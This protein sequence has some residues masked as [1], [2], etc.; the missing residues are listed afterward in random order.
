MSGSGALEELYAPASYEDAS[1][2]HKV[3]AQL[4]LADIQ[5]IQAGRKGKWRESTQLTD[6]EYALQLFAEEANALLR[7]AEDAI[8][9]QSL[10]A[11]VDADRSALEELARD[12]VVARADREMALALHAG[13]PATQRP[14]TPYSLFSIDDEAAMQTLASLSPTF[15][16][17]PLANSS[18]SVASSSKATLPLSASSRITVIPKA[19]KD[20]D[21][22][23]CGDTIQ[24]PQIRAPCGHFYDR[25]CLR[26]LFRSASV[27]ESLFPPRCCQRP[28]VFL[29]VQQYLG[30]ELAAFFQKKAVE[31]GTLDR[32]YCHRP[33]CSAFLG[34]ATP[35]PTVKRCPE[36]RA[37]TCG[38]CK[39]TAHGGPCAHGDAED[40]AVLAMAE[41]EGWKRC[42][43]CHHL[44]E[45]AH[46]CYHITC[47]C[48]KEFCYVC[49]ETWKNCTCPQWEEQRLYATAEDRVRRVLPAGPPPLA[50]ELG[51][52]VDQ[53]ADRLRADHDCA[54][55][56]WRY[57]SGGGQCENCHHYLSVFLMVCWP[58]FEVYSG[59]PDAVL[60]P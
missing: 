18:S 48:R 52:M 50:F 2:V 30:A 56:S 21:C 24:G 13:Q 42:P 25:G 33:A 45:L 3:V 40:A 34:A 14:S 35:N 17:S 15:M 41:N 11:A 9:A 27:D 26:D 28:F 58:V 57:R 59:D 46:G 49:T 51:Q 55:H 4:S 31:F 23:I 53:M 38:R 20:E 47:R 54:P 32:V 1:L 16:K 8:F 6:E 39:G 7:V 37:W 22:V 44:V 43:G 5:A 19:A 60:S 29:D 12:E 36:C 10:A